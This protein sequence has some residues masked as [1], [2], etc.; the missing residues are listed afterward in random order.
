MFITPNLHN[1]SSPLK[2]QKYHTESE[3]CVP[4]LNFSF[5]KILR[6]F[7]N[8]VQRRILQPMKFEMRSD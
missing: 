3:N 4:K 2:K 1:L 5:T 8:K 7:Q 6:L